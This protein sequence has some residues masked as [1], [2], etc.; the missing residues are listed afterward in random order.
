VST[1]RNE[2]STPREA[3]D[4]LGSTYGG[5]RWQGGGFAASWIAPPAPRR[6]F[7]VAPTLPTRDDDHA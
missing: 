2:S 1:N 5:E 3:G 7:E 4:T 6:D